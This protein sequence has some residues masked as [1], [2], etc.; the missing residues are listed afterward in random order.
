MR[1]ATI[2]LGATLLAPRLA[3][4]PQLDTETVWKEFLQWYRAAPA[5]V[6]EA[7]FPEEAYRTKLLEDGVPEAEVTRRYVLLS[8]L[9]SER[10]EALEICPPCQH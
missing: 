5:Q 3:A 2:L 7:A 8:K 9:E 6:S 1:F 10:T 4:Q